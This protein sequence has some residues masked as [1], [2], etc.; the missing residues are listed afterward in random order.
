M[1]VRFRKS[2][3]PLLA[4][5]ALHWPDGTTK[6]RR[7]SMASCTRCL[8]IM[9]VVA[10]L[11]QP[12]RGTP[13]D[14]SN[15]FSPAETFPTDSGYTGYAALHGDQLHIGMSGVDVQAGGASHWFVA[16][17]AAGAIGTTAGIL[18]NSQQPSL[19]FAATHALL[20]R[21][22]GGSTQVMEFNGTSWVPSS[23]A[24][25]TAENGDFFEAGV[26][27]SGIGS[28]TTVEFASYALFEG[29]G[30]ETSYAPLPS[31]AFT[32]GYDPDLASSVTLVAPA[33]TPVPVGPEALLA[34]AAALLG[35]GVAWLARRGRGT[36]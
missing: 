5:R 31:D 28:P 6:K 4:P 35:L 30:S 36:T 27:L 18:F 3:V 16:Y 21:M 34:A 17:F 26:S 32:A 19:P 1:A 29:S 2:A 13:V 15:S 11:G 24:A 20:Y 22:D 9:F 23:V 12:A 8:A 7:R 14:G 10:G 33:A 25:S